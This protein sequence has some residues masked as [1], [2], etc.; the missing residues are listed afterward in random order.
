MCNC[1]CNSSNKTALKAG[2]VK[3]VTYVSVEAAAAA[4]AN[5]AMLAYCQNTFSVGGVM[6]DGTGKV[7]NAIHNNVVMNNKTNDPTAHGER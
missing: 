6:L 3:D 5:Q 1:N 7:L 2:V 4:A